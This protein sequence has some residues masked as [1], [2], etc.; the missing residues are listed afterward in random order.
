MIGGMVRHHQHLAQNRLAGPVRNA[1]MQIDF[2]ILHHAPYGREVGT[3]RLDAFVPRGIVGG[4]LRGRPIARGPRRRNMFRFAHEFQDVPLRE[5]HVLQQFPGRV[6]QPARPDTAQCGRQTGDRGVEI[7]VRSAAVQQVD[8]VFPQ[9]LILGHICYYS[10]PSGGWK[11][12]PPAFLA[13]TPRKTPSPP[14]SKQS[15]SSWIYR[16]CLGKWFWVAGLGAVESGWADGRA[17]VEGVNLGW[18]RDSYRVSVVHCCQV[19]KDQGGRL[20]TSVGGDG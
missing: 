19:V 15:P 3:E 11:T 2:R 14:R 6:R 8:Q 12:S 13:K 5:A 9:R 16:R 4:R 20:L 18:C 10:W 17:V 1:R 7:Q